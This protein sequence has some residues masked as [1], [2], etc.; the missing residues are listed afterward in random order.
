[1]AKR[2]GM[3]ASK[4]RSRKTSLTLLF[5][6]FLIKLIGFLFLLTTSLILMLSY[7][8]A[9]FLVT[10][11]CYQLYASSP[12]NASRRCSWKQWTWLCDATSSLLLLYKYKMLKTL[13]SHVPPPCWNSFPI[14]YICIY[15]GNASFAFNH[16]IGGTIGCVMVLCNFTFYWGLTA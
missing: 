4:H 13:G 14:L 5:A 11:S 3:C 9:V 6:Y 12:S 15:Q 2:R 8:D 7:I 10:A 16:G 1:M